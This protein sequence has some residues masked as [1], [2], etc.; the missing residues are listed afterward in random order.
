MPWSKAQRRVA[1]RSVQ[2]FINALVTERAANYRALFA[3]KIERTPQTWSPT[4]L[5]AEVAS[6]PVTPPPIPV[7]LV[8]TIYR[9][10]VPPRTISSQTTGDDMQ[11]INPIEDTDKRPITQ[12]QPGN[13]TTKQPNNYPSIENIVAAQV[14]T[15]RNMHGGKNPPYIEINTFAQYILEIG[16]YAGRDVDGNV[17]ILRKRGGE[18]SKIKVIINKQLKDDQVICGEIDTCDAS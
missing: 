13:E 14:I 7:P 18:L 12:E 3:K 10:P 15:Y 5:N 9:V 17:Y 8:T 6:L 16:G 4:P 2:H 11:A 1:D